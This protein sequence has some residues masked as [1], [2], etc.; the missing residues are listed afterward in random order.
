MRDNTYILPTPGTFNNANKLLRLSILTSKTRE[1]SFQVLNRTVWTNNKAFKSRIR[2]NPNCERC[3][4]AETIKHLLCDCMHYSQLLRICLGEV[5]TIY[6]KYQCSRLRTRVEYGQLNIIYN[7]PHPSLVLLQDKLTQNTF[8]VLTQTS[9]INEST[10]HRL[11]TKWQTHKVVWLIWIP[12]FRY[13][14]PIFD[15]LG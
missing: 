3:W 13:S 10:Y 8:L 7:F 14:Y 15:T 9:S 2:L 1:T 5:I 4:H 6:L 11:Q 12:P